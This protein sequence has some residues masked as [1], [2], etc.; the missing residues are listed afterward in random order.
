LRS[1]DYEGVGIRVCAACG[2]RFARSEQIA[3]IAA[4]REVAFSD[5]QERLAD[6]VVA[7][8]DELRR[9]AAQRQPRLQA[10]LIACPGCGCTMI[11]RLFSYQHALEVDFCGVCDAYWF[12][13]DELEVL[14]ILSERLAQ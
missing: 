9:A 8:G 7:K 10:K 13:K 14:Q 1:A 6:L 3:R 11:R 4:R 2:G 12:D 5:D